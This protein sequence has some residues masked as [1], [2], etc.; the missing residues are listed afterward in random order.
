MYTSIVLPVGVAYGITSVL[1][2][3]PFDTIKTKMQAQK[4][5]ESSGMVNTFVRTLKTQHIAGLYRYLFEIIIKCMSLSLHVLYLGEL[6]LIYIS[7]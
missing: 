5:F 6:Y 7:L 1:V 4:G 3:H 2:G